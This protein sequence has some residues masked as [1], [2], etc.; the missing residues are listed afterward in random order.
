MNLVKNELESHDPPSKPYFHHLLVQGK[1]F[2]SLSLCFPIYKISMMV[3][4]VVK[5]KIMPQTCLV[6]GLG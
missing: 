6:Q 2:T 3:G 4:I 5:I 1:Y